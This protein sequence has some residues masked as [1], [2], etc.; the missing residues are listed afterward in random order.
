MAFL[1]VLPLPLPTSSPLSS[2]LFL[3]PAQS[4][5]N[6]GCTAK[7]VNAAKDQTAART[8]L[9]SK[10]RAA[11]EQVQLSPREQA[12]LGARLTVKP[13]LPCWHF[14]AL[15][16]FIHCKVQ[17]GQSPRKDPENFGDRVLLNGR[18]FWH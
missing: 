13:S 17:S 4:L 9:A 18:K 3:F 11:A 14:P 6:Q 10:S 12:A 7:E 5:P 2:S 15:S 1:K 16:K 8:V